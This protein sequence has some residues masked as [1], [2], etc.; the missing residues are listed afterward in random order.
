MFSTVCGIDFLS[1]RCVRVPVVMNHVC[2]F[3]DS[4]TFSSPA[5]FWLSTVTMTYFI[6]QIT[7]KHIRNNAD[8]SVNAAEDWCGSIH[9]TEYSLSSIVNTDGD[10]MF[11]Y[12]LEWRTIQ[13]GLLLYCYSSV[14]Y[15]DEMLMG[16][17]IGLFSQQWMW[18]LGRERSGNA[19]PTKPRLSSW[20]LNPLL[21]S[22]Q[23]HSARCHVNTRM[24][25]I[26]GH[27]LCCRNYFFIHNLP[28]IKPEILF[29][30]S[31]HTAPPVTTGNSQ[32]GRVWAHI[33]QYEVWYQTDALIE[34][35][36]ERFKWSNNNVL[37]NFF[38]HK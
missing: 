20:I 13:A 37:I 27:V 8:L 11:R 14:I 29:L 5:R 4:C 7:V 9:F 26:L 25:V 38:Q 3:P 22:V 18:I 23:L 6:V 12:R 35:A 1:N 2:Q 10:E 21:K 34:L 28:N 31:V 30:C 19:P 33:F 17:R 24:W 15:P 32:Q 36:Q 16:L